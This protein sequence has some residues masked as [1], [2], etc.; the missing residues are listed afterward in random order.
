MVALELRAGLRGHQLVARA[1]LQSQEQSA[2]RGELKSQPG[3]GPG[4]HAPGYI[5]VLR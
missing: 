1:R 2:E 3:W 4:F 5:P